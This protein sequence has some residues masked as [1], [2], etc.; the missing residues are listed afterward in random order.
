MAQLKNTTVNNQSSII[1]PA[2][3]S[4]NRPSSPQNGMLRYNSD[5]NTLELY[6]NGWNTLFSSEQVLGAAQMDMV[7]SGSVDNS[8]SI[9]QRSI[10]S[11][12]ADVNT[13]GFGFDSAGI[14][15]PDNG[16]YI[17]FANCRYNGNNERNVTGIRFHINGNDKGPLSRSS[18]NR[19]TVHDESSTNLSCIF[20]LKAGDRVELAFFDDAGNGSQSLRGNPSH[21]MVMRI[22]QPCVVTELVNNS[23]VNDF[24]SPTRLNVFN[25]SPLINTGDYSVESAGIRVPESGIYEF[26]VNADYS[27]GAD[28]DNPAFR[29]F[30]N[31]SDQ[32]YTASSAYMRGEDGH[33]NASSNM[34]ALFNLDAND[35][36]ELAFFREGNSGNSSLNG[37][38]SIAY[39]RKVG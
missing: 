28:R 38:N 27:R 33:N 5:L 12:T 1:L 10:F 13:G 14:T 39:V 22:N 29:F 15:V 4:G 16:L 21:M 37:S 3:D 7:D 8:G 34:K 2:G 20:S 9:T 31:G 11:G 19:N 25:T 30:V 6:N 26:Y 32:G 17:V 23:D 18:Y 36:L 24:T 35:R